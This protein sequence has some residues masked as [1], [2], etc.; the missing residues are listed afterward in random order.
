[1][2]LDYICASYYLWRKCDNKTIAHWFRSLSYT[3][4]NLTQLYNVYP[5]TPDDYTICFTSFQA[6]AVTAELEAQFERQIDD[7]KRAVREK[8]NIIDEKEE[9]MYVLNEKHVSS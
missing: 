3:K 2:N 7:L 1:M 8:Q 5:G 6:Q 4:I 9:E